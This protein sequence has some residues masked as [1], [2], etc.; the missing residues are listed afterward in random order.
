MKFLLSD[1]F[2]TEL[3]NNTIPR[4]LTV[5]N[6]SFAASIAIFAV[7]AALGFLTFGANASGLILNNY[8]PKDS[9]M[10]LSKIA[11][12]LSLVFSYPLAFAGARDGLLDLLKVQNRS[13]SLLNGT[14]VGILSGLTIAALIIPDVSFVMAFAGC[15]LG[16]A[17]I[18]IFPALMFRAAVRQLPNPTKLQKFE[19]KAAMASALVGLG[20]GAMGVVKLLAPGR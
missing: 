15:T 2:Y 5:V 9:L 20:F 17:L 3:K 18:Y 14:T 6:S 13:N 10:G 1:Q 19:I 11:V 12:A 16:N 4:Y 8:S 7:M